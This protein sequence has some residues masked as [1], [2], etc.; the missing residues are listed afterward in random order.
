MNHVA[1]CLLL[2]F[3][4]ASLVA[5]AEQS[6]TLKNGSSLN[7][8]LTGVEGG[9][10]A[11]NDSSLGKVFV[12]TGEIANADMPAPLTF[13]YQRSRRDMIHQGTLSARG[14]KLVFEGDDAASSDFLDFYRFENAPFSLWEHSGSLASS[15]AIAD[16]NSEELN[17]GLDAGLS[18]QH[19]IHIIDLGASARFGETDGVRST[20][21]ARL[22]GKY[23]YMFSEDIG[24][25]AREVVQHDD[26][27]DLRIG[28]VTAAGVTLPLLAENTYGLDASAGLTFTTENFKSSTNREYAGAEVGLNGFW[29]MSAEAR[30]EGS[31]RLNVS[32]EDTEDSI[33]ETRLS[34]TYKLLSDVNF[35]LVFEHDYDNLPSPGSERTDIRLTALLGLTF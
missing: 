11:F 1:L 9:K 34:M 23:R 28:T 7:G 27:K 14:G 17:Y 4:S 8:E 20:Q 33:I 18:F 12:P 35:S 25:Y 10:L 29:E 32:L 15:L 24:V 30:F 5:Q 16:G 22:E 2:L 13:H 3:G 31:T 19:P 26:F 6:L 21:R